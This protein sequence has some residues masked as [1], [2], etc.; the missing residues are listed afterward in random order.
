MREE[1]KELC[2]CCGKAKVEWFEPCPVCGWW[3]DFAQTDDP[4]WA[5]GENDISLNVARAK[6]KATK[7]KVA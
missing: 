4:A 1:K 5:E 3:N 6:W 2:S 7:K